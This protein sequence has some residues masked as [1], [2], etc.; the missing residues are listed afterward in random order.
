MKNYKIKMA[1]DGTHYHGFQRQNNAYTIQEAVETALYRLTGETAVI[2]GCSRTDT[3]VHARE[4]YFNVRLETAIT[5]RGIV[6]GVNNLLEND[7]ALLTCEEAAPEF[8]AR[9]DCR[10]KEY[11]YLIHNSEIKNPFW[12]N[13]AY[14]FWYPI[15][16]TLLHDTA[17][18][19]VGTHDFRSCCAAACTKENTVR[20]IH[21]FSVTRTGEM[22]SFLIRG[23]GFLYNMVRILVGTLLYVNDG[24]ISPARIREILESKNRTLAG[25]TV[26]PCGLYL[27][28]VYYS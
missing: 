8:H 12:N 6:F 10:G 3:G 26:P 14:R 23:D 18:I 25:K 16:E 13:R 24:K 28:H 11:E 17:Q 15:Q 4:F 20:T 9:Y 22:V 19:F 27:N 1:Y 21:Q 5:C 2:Y 7:I